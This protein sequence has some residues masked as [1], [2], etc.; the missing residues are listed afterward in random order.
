MNQQSEDTTVPTPEEMAELL[1]ASG[2]P[3]DDVLDLL[4]QA[5]ELYGW[6]DRLNKTGLLYLKPG[7]LY[8]KET[9]DAC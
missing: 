7:A 1:R 5:G 8:P 3:E 6:N 4:R 9:K 2:M